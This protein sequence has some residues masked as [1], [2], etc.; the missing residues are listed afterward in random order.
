M[1]MREYDFADG[2][3][4]PQFREGRWPA[5][6]R[7]GTHF[8]QRT[9]PGEDAA[10]G[11]IIVDDQHRQPGESRRFAAVARSAAGVAGFSNR[12]AEMERAPFPDLAF[13]RNRLPP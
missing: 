10:V 13:D 7:L 11:L 2:R 5:L 3:R 1:S 6:D 8:P 4:A 9:E 12:I